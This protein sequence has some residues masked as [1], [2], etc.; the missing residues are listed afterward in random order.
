VSPSAAVANGRR[1]SPR[2]QRRPFFTCTDAASKRWPDTARTAP[3]NGRLSGV[4]R[5]RG[6]DRGLS[7]VI[8]VKTPKFT[9]NCKTCYKACLVPV[10]QCNPNIC[11][12]GRGIVPTTNYRFMKSPAIAQVKLSY[13]VLFVRLHT[14]A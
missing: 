13:V 5:Y 9:E 4:D 6:K 14:V 7:L 11:V 3:R 10:L 12:C 8:C 2:P 1:G